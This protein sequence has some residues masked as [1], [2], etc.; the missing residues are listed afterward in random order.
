MD[1]THLPTFLAIAVRDWFSETHPVQRLWRI[2]DA[3]ELWTKYVATV[4]LA[5]R[6]REAGG[7]LPRDLAL[8]LAGTI[9][10][11]TFG[12]WVRMAE[13]VLPGI[14]GASDFLSRGTALFLEARA[15][16]TPGPASPPEKG[17]LYL[18]NYLAHGGGLTLVAGQRLLEE[19]GHQ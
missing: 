11:P 19:E 5:A 14:G 13:A 9:E 15:L 10:R 8:R 6:V 4:G 7:R 2:C 17:I 3:M 18:R 1:T 12:F 16:L